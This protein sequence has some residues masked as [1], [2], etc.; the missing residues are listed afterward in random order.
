MPSRFT[1]VDRYTCMACGLTTLREE[2]VRHRVFDVLVGGAPT[3]APSFG[4]ITTL[5]PTGIL[6]DQSEATTK[7]DSA[8]APTSL[9]VPPV[10]TDGFLQTFAGSFVSIAYL[11]FRARVSVEFAD[12][13]PIDPP[14]TLVWALISNG[15]TDQAPD[16]TAFPTFPVF[17]TLTSQQ[18]TTDPDG[19]PWDAANINDLRMYV[20]FAVDDGGSHNLTTCYVADLWAEV[21][22]VS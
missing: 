17:Q 5:R 21:W 11:I 10:A 3:S 13:G 18:A 16:D 8:P 15:D 1:H 7:S 2:L 12:A 6:G 20:G 22:G 14:A 19:N 9:I 4:L